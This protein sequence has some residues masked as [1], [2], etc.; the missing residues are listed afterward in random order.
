MFIQSDGRCPPVIAVNNAVPSTL[1]ASAG[2]T[3]DF[4]CIQGYMYS[5]GSVS[6]QVVCGIDLQWTEVADVCQGNMQ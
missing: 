4:T 1:V 6:K 5:D 3:V 2:T